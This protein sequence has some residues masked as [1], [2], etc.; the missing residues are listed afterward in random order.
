M[1]K[2]EPTLVAS[3]LEQA[4]DLTGNRI[5]WNEYCLLLYLGLIGVVGGPGAQLFLW[6]L[7]FRQGF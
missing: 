3:K 4:N 7:V 1:K 2:E 5:A 6:P